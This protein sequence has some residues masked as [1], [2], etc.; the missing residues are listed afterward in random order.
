MV[1]TSE[2]RPQARIGGVGTILALSV[3]G[4]GLLVMSGWAFDIAHFKS[5]VPGLATMKPNTAAAFLLSGLALY[6][7]LP[8]PAR[9][10]RPGPWNAPLA[11]V[12]AFAVGL[13]GAASLIEYLINRDLGLDA[14]FLLASDLPK[15]NAPGRMAFATALNFVLV[16]TGLLAMGAATRTGKRPT[17]WAALFVAANSFLALLGY[18]FGADALY[19]IGGFSSVALH[20]ALCFIALSAGMV[21]A[22][23]K[24]DFVLKL[25]GRHAAGI[26]NRRLLPAALLVPPL[27]GFLCRS[28]ERAGLYTEPFTFALFAGANVAVFAGLAWWSAESIH[29][30]TEQ[31]R[32]VAEVSAWQQSILDSADF[33]VISTDTEGVIQ[34]FNAVAE[35]KLGY[36]AADLI[37]KATPSL[38]HDPAEVAARAATLS[39]ELGRPVP[40]GFEAFVARAR[41][42]V[43]DEQPWTYIRRD[44]TR[45]PVQLSVTPLIGAE[46]RLTGFLGLGKDLSAQK[47]AEEALAASEHLVQVI[48]DNIPALV[49]YIDNEERYRFVNARLARALELKPEEILGRTIR[50]IRGSTI[51]AAIGDKV[52][53]PLKGEP[54]IFEGKGPGLERDRDYRFAHMPD[55]TPTGEIRGFYALALDI[56]DIKRAEAQLVQLAQFDS[57][58]GLPNR[59][60]FNDRLADAIARSERSGQTMALM[61]LDLDGFKE[62][63]DRHGHRGG[64]EA[65]QEFSRRLE[66]SVRA[67][68]T[69][70]RFAGDEFVVILES[71]NHREEAELVA[72]KIL[73]A[74]RAPFEVGGR[75]VPL[76]TSIGIAIRRAGEVDGD[77]LLR[78]ADMAVYQMKREGRGG[79][80]IAD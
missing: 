38:I 66:K 27:L 64:D 39:E 63:N 3:A 72:G 52:A 10:F 37:D 77:A 2:S 76:S 5:V 69:V 28:G 47:A 33:M 40:A 55:E 30:V 62:I 9:P 17:H 50:E 15:A 26:I 49:A 44:G 13:I 75:P 57:L 16:A 29:R 6:L 14:W 78:R 43:S 74:L 35:R 60:R 73:A 23:P 65:L 56:S 80:R 1:R 12:L 45:F 71:L 48:A 54:L 24:S 46:G 67:T 70:A 18:L 42:G 36:A 22:Q 68:D 31:R 25:C 51:Y 58:T 21:A 79:F 41:Q 4:I 19:R 11:R 61:F 32:A 20:T 53:R 7:L 34:T 59:N 8:H